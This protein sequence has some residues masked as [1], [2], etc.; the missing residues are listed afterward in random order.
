MSKKK[1]TIDHEL[2]I[3]ECIRDNPGGVTISDIA[4]ITKFSR[5]TISKYVSILE[6]T[7]QIFSKKVGAYK[8]YFSMKKSYIPYETAITY[9]K[10]LLS[11]IKKYFPNMENIAK[12]I[13]REAVKDIKFTFGPSMYKQLKSIKDHPISRIHL[14]G[15]KN[16]YSAYDIFQPNIDISIL[17][18]DPEGK[19][20]TYRFKNSV[21]L[22]DSDDFIYHLYIMCGISE[23]ILTKVLKTEISCEIEQIYI[24]DNKE[25][26]F[27][28]LKIKIK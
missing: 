11:K 4:N 27:F 2:V 24:S 16:F 18:I 17:K 7:D 3:L 5:N 6:R 8:L 9:Y 10:A 15:F 21:F 19:K 26:S 14:E 23:G 13:G 20:A 25:K 28:D 12:K 1:N 22:E